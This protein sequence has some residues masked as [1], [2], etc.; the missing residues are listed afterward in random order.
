MGINKQICTNQHIETVR[1]DDLFAN[2]KEPRVGN[3]EKILSAEPMCLPR[4]PN[5][6]P[7]NSVLARLFHHPQPRREFARPG[8]GGDSE[9]IFGISENSKVDPLL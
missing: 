6:H 1:K 4:L 8:E 9:S 5:S 7:P 2:S 3:E